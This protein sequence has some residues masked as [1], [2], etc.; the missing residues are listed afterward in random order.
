MEKKHGIFFGFAVLLITAIF[1]LAGCD[2]NG[3]DDG[4]GNTP[5]AENLVAVFNHSDAGD[6][7]SF[8][9]ELL[10]P[11]YSK[12]SEVSDTT[13]WVI[14]GNT[15]KL[16]A[17]VPAIKAAYDQGAFIG[18]LAPSHADYH[19]FV[20]QLEHKSTI[21]FDAT[22]ASHEHDL[23]VFNKDGHTYIV[24]D[25]E[26]STTVA[27]HAPTEWKSTGNYTLEEQ[28]ENKDAG[29]PGDHPAV[30]LPEHESTITVAAADI[31]V[32]QRKELVNR[33]IAFVEEH[34][35]KS[36]TGH[37]ATLSSASAARSAA[38]GVNLDA[39]HVN[40]SYQV[41]F[42][43][44]GTGHGEVATSKW[45]HENYAIT[46]V[47]SYSEDRDYYMVEQEVEMINGNLDI[48]REH[49]VY[50][51]WWGGEGIE[52]YNFSRGMDVENTLNTDTGVYCTQVSPQTTEGSSN[53]TTGVS[54]NIGGNIGLSGSGPSGGVSGGITIS[55]SHSTNIPDVSVQNWSGQ[56]GPKSTWWRYDIAWPVSDSDYWDTDHY[57]WEILP[58]PAIART[59]AVYNQ[60]WIWIVDNPKSRNNGQYGMRSII[61]PRVGW[62]WGSQTWLGYYGQ[63]KAEYWGSN[64]TSD[65]MFK[66]PK[67]D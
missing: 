26:R 63:N 17:E 14:I 58:E 43:V 54:Y 41:N 1:T 45:V 67:R 10:S 16:T 3:G 4:G 9:D 49:V 59:T 40:L 64:N 42:Q 52:S 8:L 21:S 6:N 18:L 22:D 31:T 34:T 50:Y 2:I 11:I 12:G 36:L 37:P 47:Y 46:A 29:V 61:S 53:F 7:V 56:R 30:T 39:Q 51:D 24:H 27:F 13:V 44:K 60:T 65:I 5:N 55:N 35:G 38:S 25:L 23:I 62:M 48:V 32:A 19:S 28:D 20:D 33:V 15:G 57:R 66:Q